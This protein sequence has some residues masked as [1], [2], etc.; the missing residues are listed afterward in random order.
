EPTPLSLR[1]IIFGGEA[2]QLEELRVWI[3]RRGE[4]QPCL[5]NMYGITE[6]TVHVTERG[7]RQADIETASGS[8]IGQALPDLSLAV[9]DPFGLPLPPGVAGEL[10]VGGA[11]V[12]RGYLHRPAL[13][14]ERFLPASGGGRL[15]RSGD[16]V[17]QT[18]GDIE[19]LGRIDQ[20]V[21]VRGFR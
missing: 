8:A 12:A 11:G 21:K 3:A 20:Q 2:L 15:Y 10:H 4:V 17:R 9:L 5:T 19:Y 16:L 7:I 13:T 6:T 18:T 14:A 1:H